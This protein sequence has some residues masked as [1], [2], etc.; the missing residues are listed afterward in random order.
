MPAGASSDVL[1]AP[2]V[3]RTQ[4]EAELVSASAWCRRHGWRV[5][6]VPN[7]PL[8]VVRAVHPNGQ[9][10]RLTGLFDDY[11]ALPPTW[12]FCRRR[13]ASAYSGW[14]LPGSGPTSSIF[15]EA[16]GRPIMCAP[17]SRDAFQESGGPHGDWGGMTAW[18]NVTSAI[19][20]TT[21]GDMLAAIWAH[22]MLSPGVRT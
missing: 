17:F 21:I 2:D 8:L 11:R 6:L 22:L 14:P 16:A 19:R 10:L 5:R 18:E 15:I 1:V 13:A 3:T 20:A 9:R 4:V 12:R 7:R